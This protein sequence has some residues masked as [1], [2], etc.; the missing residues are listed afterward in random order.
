MMA[1][2]FRLHS[3]TFYFSLLL[4]VPMST[5]VYAWDYKKLNNMHSLIFVPSL[6]VTLYAGIKSYGQGNSATKRVQYFVQ[7]PSRVVLTCV[8]AI[9][10]Y[11]VFRDI[12]KNI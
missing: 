4:C 12:Y 10:G 9:S 11:L 6:I 2:M 8:T 7:D 5:N 1:N 3:I